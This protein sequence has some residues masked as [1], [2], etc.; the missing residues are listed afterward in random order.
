MGLNLRMRHY[1][2]N[3]SE[4][5]KASWSEADLCASDVNPDLLWGNQES[6]VLS[7]HEDHKDHE[8]Y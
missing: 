8:G 5:G 2:A 1:C 7:N 4:P 6:N 3:L